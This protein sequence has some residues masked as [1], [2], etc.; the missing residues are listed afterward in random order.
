MSKKIQDKQGEEDSKEK[1]YEERKSKGN[2]LI[3]K[4]HMLFLYAY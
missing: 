4:V 1:G 3:L 2:Q